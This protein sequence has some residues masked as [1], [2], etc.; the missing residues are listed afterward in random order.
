MGYK[1]WSVVNDTKIHT[2]NGKIAQRKK[3]DNLPIKMS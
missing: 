2:Q 3:T 1:A